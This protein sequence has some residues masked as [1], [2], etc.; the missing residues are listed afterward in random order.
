MKFHPQKMKL[1]KKNMTIDH[2]M[3][4]MTLQVNMIQMAI[5]LNFYPDILLMLAKLKKSKKI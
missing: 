1:N 5:K 3:I 4:P 2:Q